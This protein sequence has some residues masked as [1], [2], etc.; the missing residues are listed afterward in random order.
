MAYIR[1]RSKTWRAEVQIDDIRRSK[2]F[3]TK[4]EAEAW[5]KVQE[6]GIKRRASV[7]RNMGNPELLSMIPKRVM[8]AQSEI[9]YSADEIVKASIP[10]SFVSGVYFLIQADEIVY[11]GQ[12]V[13]VMSRIAQ[14]R[15]D[16]EKDFDSFNAV[17]CKP[18]DLDR[19]EELYINAFVPRFNTV[20]SPKTVRY[21]RGAGT[22]CR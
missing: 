15:R 20:L 5:A 1:E 22:K 3:P 14:H 8:L 18:E 9:P 6:T 12:S 21:E 4:E 2:T 10:F 17:P 19:L 7:K 11:V 16:G 13:N